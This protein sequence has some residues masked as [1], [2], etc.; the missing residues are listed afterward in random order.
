MGLLLLAAIGLAVAIWQTVM[1]VETT[2][3]ST[4]LVFDK[5]PSWREGN[6]A[7]VLDPVWAIEEKKRYPADARLIDAMVDAFRSGDIDYYAW[8]EIDGDKSQPDGWVSAGSEEYPVAPKSL[9]GLALTSGATAPVHILPGIDA[10]DVTLPIGP[11]ARLDYSYDTARDDGTVDIVYVRSYWLIDGPSVIAVQL[12][13]YGQRPDVV[14][15]FDA[16][17]ATFRWAP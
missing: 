11:S 5:P 9:A 16:V 7:D 1:P 13:T 15:N 10:I 3:A 12:V 17:A 6:R 4:R 8:I 2:I 14:A